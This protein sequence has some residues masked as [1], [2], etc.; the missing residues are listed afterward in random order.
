MK[1]SFL[2]LKENNN[3]DRFLASILEVM[4]YNIKSEVYLIT[5]DIN[6]QNKAEYSMIP[7]LE[8]PEK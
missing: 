8:P 5:S 7:F 3:D 2:G 6:L 4:R 1:E